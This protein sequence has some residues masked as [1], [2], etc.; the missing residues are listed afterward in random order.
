[1]AKKAVIILNDGPNDPNR[2]TVA[3][4]TAKALK[5]AGMEVSIWLYNDSTY[6]MKKGVIENVQAPGLPPLEDLFLYLSM[7]AK[8]PIYIGVSCAEGRGITKEEIEYGE[9]A[10]PPKLAELISEAD[11]V[12]GF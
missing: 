12:I 2:A 3:F 9:L 5:E 7:N 11:V 10:G 8:V 1:M 4:L 6:L